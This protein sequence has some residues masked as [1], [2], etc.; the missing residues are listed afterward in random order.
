MDMRG[1]GPSASVQ[2]HAVRNPIEVQLLQEQI[3]LLGLDSCPKVDLLVIS[4]CV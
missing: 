4:F 2:D 3:W 1:M